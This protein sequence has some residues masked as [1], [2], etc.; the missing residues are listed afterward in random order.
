MDAHG[1]AAT[2]WPRGRTPS[3]R[4]TWSA[5]VSLFLFA[6]AIAHLAG[7]SRT[8]QAAADGES[9]DYLGGAWQIS[10]PLALRLAG[11]AWAVVAVAYVAAAAGE[12]LGWR[13]WW[14][15]VVGVTVFSLILA[16]IA[17]WESW[18]GV[19]VDVGIL[20][21]W[22]TTERSQPLAAVGEARR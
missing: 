20:A 17:L 7:T 8:F 22:W 11:T 15:F 13:R 12:W 1:D 18:I 5:G 2:F 6:H 3:T 16:L 10:N 9:V 14:T 19:V 21:V 4:F